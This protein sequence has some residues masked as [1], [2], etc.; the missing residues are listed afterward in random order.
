MLLQSGATFRA[1]SLFAVFYPDTV[2]GKM[3]HAYSEIER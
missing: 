1:I 3:A 2:V